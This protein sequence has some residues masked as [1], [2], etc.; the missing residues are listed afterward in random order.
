MPRA[1]ASTLSAR[2]LRE[3]KRE[4]HKTPRTRRFFFFFIL[5]RTS[6]FSQ[7]ARSFFSFLSPFFFFLS[8][9][10]CAPILKPNNNNKKNTGPPRPT[11]PTPRTSSPSCSQ[12]AP[13]TTP[14]RRR[15]RPRRSLW[16]RFFF[17]FFFLFACE[18]DK[19][20]CCR[21]GRTKKKK[22]WRQNLQCFKHLESTL[23]RF[24]A[25]SRS[26]LFG[27]G[28]R[29]VSCH[30]IHRLIIETWQFR[31]GNANEGKT[32]NHEQRKKKK[33]KRTFD[34]KKR[35]NVSFLTLFVP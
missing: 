11:G 34:K 35:K 26:P 28:S 15:L 1:F 12:E 14:W 13:R 30:R 19:E 29:G 27:G 10:Q 20:R 16:V 4:K 9:L 21:E 6:R 25:V 22:T 7:Q 33:K 17:L 24:H 32:K 5:H 3:K 31:T 23:E 8:H 2:C 18:I